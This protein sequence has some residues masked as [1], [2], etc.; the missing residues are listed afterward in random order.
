MMPLNKSNFRSNIMPLNWVKKKSNMYNFVDATWNTVKGACPHGCSYCYMRRWGKQA[1]LHFDDQ[2]LKTDL[3]SGN[4][5]FVG[6]SC[7][8]WAWTVPGEWIMKTLEHCSKSIPNTFLFQSKNPARFPQFY[9]HYPYYSSHDRIVDNVIFAT[10][11]ETNREEY[12]GKDAPAI[13]DRYGGI[14]TVCREDGGRCMVTIEPIMDFDLKPMIEMLSDIEPEQVNIG[15]D[16]GNNH[17]PEPPAEKVRE[18]IGELVLFTKVHQKPNLN[19]ILKDA[20]NPPQN[21]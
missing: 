9:G 20:N 8:M 12:I 13:L 14:E 17:L 7:D 5:I 16:S 2:E 18:L 11:I 19:R 21:A 10:T 3:G 4:T 15:A 6:S 1:P